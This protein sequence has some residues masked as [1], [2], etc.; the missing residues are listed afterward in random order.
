MP[1]SF[2]LYCFHAVSNNEET[3]NTKRGENR[4]IACELEGKRKKE[5]LATEKTI[6]LNSIFSFFMHEQRADSSLL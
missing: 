1:S 4:Q 6:T 3:P 2:F 5:K